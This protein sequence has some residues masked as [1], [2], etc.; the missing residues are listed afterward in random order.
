MTSRIGV[1]TLDARDPERIAEFWCRVLGW[2]I[3]ER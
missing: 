3:L 2:S 1:V